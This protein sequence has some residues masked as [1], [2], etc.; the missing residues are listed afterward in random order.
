MKS[1]KQIT[2]NKIIVLNLVI[3]LFNESY[4][5]GNLNIKLKRDNQYDFNF[6]NTYFEFK[7]LDGNGKKQMK[8]TPHSEAP[9]RHI[10]KE[11]YIVTTCTF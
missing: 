6:A 2:I 8:F 1:I 7:F 4:N 9:I 3:L 11:S 5:Q 10:I